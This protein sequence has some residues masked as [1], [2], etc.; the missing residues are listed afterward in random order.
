MFDALRRW[1][2]REARPHAAPAAPP[3]NADKLL[4][5]V[6]SALQSGDEAEALRLLEALT[7]QHP[8]LAEAHCALGELLARRGETDE[9]RD[10]FTLA[11]HFAPGS[12]R[13]HY[14]LGTLELSQHHI[15]AAVR[16]ITQALE[17][18]GPN[19]AMYNTLG[20]AHA[21]AGDHVEAVACFRK[22]V[23]IAPDFAEAHS[24]LGCVLFRELEEQ[25][26]GPAAIERAIELGAR[27]DAVWVNRA[28]V[29]HRRGE[30]D[31]ALA[32]YDDLLARDPGMAQ[33]RLNRALIRLA[34]GDFAAGWDDYEA[35]RSLPGAAPTPA[36]AGEWDGDD[37]QGRSLLV[38]PEQGLGD[39]IMFASCIP[40]L[41]RMEARCALRC[42]PKLETL[43]R[44]SF[45]A[46]DVARAHGPVSSAA[47]WDRAISIASLPRF[48]RRSRAAFP[49]HGAYLHADPA[50]VEHW[51]ARLGALPGRLKVGLSW[52]GGLPSTRRNL[53]SIPLPDWVDVLRI[54]GVDFVSLQYTDSTREIEE[55][56]RESDVTIHEWKDAI[57]D[58]DETAALVAALDLVISVQTSVVHLAGALGARTWAL[59]PEVPEWRYG[60]HGDTMPWYPSVTLWRKQRGE[61]WVCVLARVARALRER[62]GAA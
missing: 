55:L 48:L 11:L 25:D 6:A 21:E 39:E 62:A 50:R 19:A 61:E 42:N 17:H 18:G 51:R 15:P 1:F 27:G 4:A 37:L 16:S 28:M 43:F 24:N 59:I 44:R 40:D 14:A 26:E 45:P 10:S 23:A 47:Q 9:A 41:L 57:A 58:Y 53:R 56:S 33:A 20:A 36:G 30:I 35:R 32:V 5:P 8:E 52:R 3:A 22:A 46:A 49:A 29:W 13:A 31:R 12:A 60:E 7:W 2:A 38:Y 34:R 54:P